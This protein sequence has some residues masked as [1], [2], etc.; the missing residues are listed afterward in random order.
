MEC[1]RVYLRILCGVPVDERDF[2]W[3]DLV[4]ASG[5]IDE[6]EVGVFLS[7]NRGH[8]ILAGSRA[9]Y[10][11]KQAQI[12]VSVKFLI[13]EGEVSRRL[14]T[15]GMMAQ[16][17]LQ[18]LP[19]LDELVVGLAGAGRCFMQLVGGCVGKSQ[20]NLVEILVKLLGLVQDGQVVPLL[21]CWRGNVQV[22]AAPEHRPRH[23]SVH[24]SVE[25]DVSAAER[26][27]SGVALELEVLDGNDFAAWEQSAQLL[28]GGIGVGALG[29][30]REGGTGKQDGQGEAAIPMVRQHRDRSSLEIMVAIL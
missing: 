9:E 29:R 18:L 22:A 27:S 6:K 17:A 24:L 8:E 21:G 23:L 19:S 10:V 26:E 25:G 11:L 30:E 1:E 5:V 16:K 28:I 12:E 7:M 3:S 15:F 4:D 20:N 13:V 14:R 2:L